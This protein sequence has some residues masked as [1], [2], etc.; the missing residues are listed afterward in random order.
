MVVKRILLT[1]QKAATV[2]PF[3]K[4][5]VSAATT[6]IVLKLG[7]CGIMYPWS[8]LFNR[9]IGNAES[10]MGHNVR[11]RDYVILAAVSR[12]EVRV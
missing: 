8:R 2:F 3:G 9:W 12:S 10:E 4:P 11:I 1:H 5:I 6:D 7:L